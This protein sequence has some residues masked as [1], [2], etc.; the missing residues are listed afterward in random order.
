MTDLIEGQVATAASDQS[1]A[2]NGKETS[3]KVDASSAVEEVLEMDLSSI[4]KSE[5]G[6]FEL[7]DPANPEKTVY[8]GKTVDELLKNVIKGN[9]E[10]DKFISE[11]KAKSISSDRF[12]DTKTPK[13]EEEGA[14]LQF[15]DPDEVLQN[16]V[17]EMRID[18]AM[19]AWTREDW[20][21]HEAENGAVETLE[22]KSQVDQAR[23]IAQGR[24]AEENVRVIN[25]NNL[26]EET[27][28]I[29]AMVAEE[30]LNVDDIDWD[31]VFQEAITDPK[32]Y[33]KS[34]IRRSGT[35]VARAEREIR[36]VLKDKIRGE[37][38]KKLET[39][40]AEGRRKGK[41][42]ETPGSTAGA[43]H[44]P[45]TAPAKNFD[46]AFDRALKAFQ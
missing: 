6:Q 15:P 27:D 5:D 25:A 33:N 23:K 39:E 3:P 35:V 31:N 34:G 36:R 11:L 4:T 24:V 26:E 44:S 17:K 13:G 16:V 43:S 12:R 37:E 2:G 21:K 19:L 46:E 22:L 10:K 41:E 18:G 9:T 14:Q 32:H 30:G 20:K 45:K 8:R 28:T 42:M 38:S 1:Q 40:I 7:R 29:R